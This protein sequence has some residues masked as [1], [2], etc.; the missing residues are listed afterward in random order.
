MSDRSRPCE[1]RHLCALCSL[2][3]L[4]WGPDACAQNTSAA[5]GAALFTNGPL[6]V[7]QITIPPEA[8]AELRTNSRKY[9]A[10]TIREGTNTFEPTGVHLKG[11]VGSFRKLDDKPGFTLSFDKFAPDLR[12]HGLR[13]IHLN[14]SVEDPSY[15]NELL[16]HEIFR[17]AGIPAPRVGHARVELNGRPL[18]LYVLK[19]GFTEDF[20][21]LHFRH[22]SGNL[23]DPGSGHD[24][25]ESLEKQLGD[26][27]EDRSDLLALAAAACEPDLTG[28]W[29]R[30][31]GTLDVDRF[32]TFMALEMTIGHRDGY[33]LSRN[34]FRVYHDVDSGRLMF[35]PHG[36]DQL[37]GNAR[38]PIEP[39][40]NG[41]VARAVIE[42]PQGRQEY[43][44]RCASLLTN[45]LIVSNLAARI[46]AALASLRPALTE[47]ERSAL[48]FCA[49]G[50]RIAACA[51]LSRDR[52]S[53]ARD[54]R[55]MNLG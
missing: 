13:R 9:V 35:L 30:L 52:R 6:R 31:R 27:P 26:N 39:R 49:R 46:D 43:R 41:L 1:T 11:S 17:Q 4:L 42:I 10:A 23:Y 37:F 53:A 33:C 14:N 32:I 20:L 34:N 45:V 12:F 21:A 19:E 47:A 48:D 28:R 7:I 24:V 50:E 29:Q 36:M 25:D 8:V 5:A 18:G 38:I 16:G 44:Q 40:M 51:H 54:G 22:P 55:V 15:M 2:L 3:L